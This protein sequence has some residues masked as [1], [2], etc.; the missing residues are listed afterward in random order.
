MVIYYLKDLK[1]EEVEKKNIMMTTGDK[2]IFGVGKSGI[3]F[4]KQLAE[5]YDLPTEPKAV[6]IGVRFE[7][8]QH[9]FQKLIDMYHMI[10][11]YIENLKIKVFH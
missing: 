9:H 10:L 5:Q 6:Q 1:T 3:D 4:G 7:A 2:L 11:N 8:P